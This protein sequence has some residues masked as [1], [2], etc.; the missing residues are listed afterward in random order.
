[1]K[2]IWKIV[3]IVIAFLCITGC[4]KNNEKLIAENLEKIDLT[5]DLVTYE[6]YYHNVVEYEQEKGTGITHIL[7]KDRKMFIEYTGTIKLGIDMSKVEVKVKGKEIDVYIPKAKIIGEPNIDKDTFK[8]EN[9]IQSKEGINKNKI[10]ADDSEAAFRKAQENIKKEA[11]ENDKILALAQKR[12][13]V[14]LEN[15][16]KAVINLNSSQYEI[17]WE[18]GQ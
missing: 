14:I 9:F 16:I 17:N 2:K 10:T 7:E 5:G 1:M 6:A 18:Y 13:K 12:A 11:M 8:K 4:N 15:N 3:V